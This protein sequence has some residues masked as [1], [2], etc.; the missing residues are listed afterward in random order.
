MSDWVKCWCVG[1]I[2]NAL[3]EM[4]TSQDFQSRTTKHCSDQRGLEIWGEGGRGTFGTYHWSSPP[5]S[6]PVQ[7][8]K[9]TY[10][11]AESSNAVS[12]PW[13][14]P[15]LIYA[16]YNTLCPPVAQSHIKISFVTD[17][18]LRVIE[19]SDRYRNGQKGK[20]KVLMLRAMRCVCSFSVLGYREHI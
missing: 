1:G 17:N 18:F 7:S 4:V 16:I 5:H 8:H 2:Q 6:L 10:L 12:N 11:D 13:S 15:E 9:S 3:T 14:T 20:I 19:P